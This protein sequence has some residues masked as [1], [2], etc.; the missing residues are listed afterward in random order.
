MFKK[1][2]QKSAHKEWAFLLNPTHFKGEGLGFGTSAAELLASRFHLSPPNHR[3]HR[4]HNREGQPAGEVN[5]D[6]LLSSLPFF[7]Q[8]SDKLKKTQN[9]N[10]QGIQC[11]LI[12]I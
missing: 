7:I 10:A 4:A 8:L 3:V 6:S 12:P 11:N 5:N 1:K 2:I 9:K